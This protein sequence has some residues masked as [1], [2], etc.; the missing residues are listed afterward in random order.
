MAE[1][2]NWAFPR[3]LQPSP[4]DVDFDLDAGLNSAVLLRAEIPEEAFTASILGTERAGYGV[5][6]R[7]DGLILT[8]G[9]LITEAASIWLTTNQGVV[10]AGHPLAIDQATG[11]GL[12]LPLGRLGAP[13]MERGSAATLDVGDDVIVIGQGGRAH[14]LKARLVARREFAG[15][16]EYLLDEALFAAPAHPQW[17]GTALVG[18]DG[19][20][21]GIGSLLVQDRESLGGE[22]EQGNMFVP[23]DLLEPIL[24]DLLKAGR[25]A[26]PPR[27]WLGLY[28]AEVQ[29]QVVIS[30]VADGG[31]AAR[32]GMR[33]GDIVLELAGERVFGTADLFRKLWSL[34]PA[35]VAVPLTLA[36]KGEQVRLLARSVD[37]N[38]LFA[39]PRLH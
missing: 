18:A 15:S 24:D 32:A 28:A 16:W 30:G 34:G 38:D 26:G 2:H 27:P 4:E 20:L 17:G 31:P 3:N 9:Y 13:A 14:A 29:G 33:A 5:V 11:F 8:I 37:R 6:I 7:E 19:R 12:V 1:S 23:V 36:R 21:L 10:V 35:G 22:A 25:R 39:K